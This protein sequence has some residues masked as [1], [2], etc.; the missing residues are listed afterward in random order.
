MLQ[1]GSTE[2]GFITVNIRSR[3]ISLAAG[4]IVLGGV[5]LAVAAPVLAQEDFYLPYLYAEESVDGCADEANFNRLLQGEPFE[6]LD[7][8]SCD[9]HAVTEKLTFIG[10]HFIDPPDYKDPD[11]AFIV[12]RKY[13]M[14]TEDGPVRFIW[15]TPLSA[16]AVS[17]EVFDDLHDEPMMDYP[18]VQLAPVEIT[19][20]S[21]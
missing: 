20:A 5:I 7:A 8:V 12:A 16:A 11:D 15:P 17:F 4:L 9:S 6:K 10:W 13:V 1:G 19:I 3:L 21:Y 14:E 2:R 18:D